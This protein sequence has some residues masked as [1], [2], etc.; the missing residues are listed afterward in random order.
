M[1]KKKKK[2]AVIESAVFETVFEKFDFAFVYYAIN[3]LRRGP[4]FDLDLIVIKTYMRVY[5]I[6][7]K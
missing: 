7:C 5:C 2:K 1:K 4:F 6:A 3:V